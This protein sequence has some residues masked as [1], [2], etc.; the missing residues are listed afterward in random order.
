MLTVKDEETLLSQVGVCIPPWL[1]DSLGQRNVSPS[2]GSVYPT[3]GRVSRTE[4]RCAVKDH[5]H[6]G[7][8]GQ[9]APAT[10]NRTT[11]PGSA[12]DSQLT[13]EFGDLPA[14][15]VVQKSF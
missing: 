3:A 7:G 2:S 14:H 11:L 5:R 8:M 6:I 1:E 4:E 13:K 10:M 9:E 12:S 15:L